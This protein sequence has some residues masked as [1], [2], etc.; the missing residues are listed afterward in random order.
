MSKKQKEQTIT[1]DDIEHKVSDLTE[2]QVALVNHVQDLDRKIQSS[3]FN[4]DQL[5]VGRNAFMS[6]L[7]E[8][9]KAEE[10][11]IAEVA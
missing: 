7:S 3:Q 9:M 6:M 1:I 8:A 5:N 10:A 2:Q 11:E 4:L